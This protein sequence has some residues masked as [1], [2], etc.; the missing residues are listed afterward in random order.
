MALLKSVSISY[1]KKY[2]SFI[3]AHARIIQ[4][5]LTATAM[6]SYDYYYGYC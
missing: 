6:T 2:A 5:A 3:M 1:V 4:D